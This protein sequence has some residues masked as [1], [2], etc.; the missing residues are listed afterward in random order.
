MASFDKFIKDLERRE[1]L[2]KRREEV[3]RQQDKDH[4][5][6]RRVRLYSEKWQNRIRY[7]PNGGKK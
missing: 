3:L 2:K 6:V 7:V 1:A 5:Q 4:H